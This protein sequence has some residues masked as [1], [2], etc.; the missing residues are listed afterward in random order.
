MKTKKGAL[1]AAA[2]CRTSGEGQRDNTSIPTQREKIQDFAKANGWTVV[3]WYIDECRS[4]AKIEGRDQFKLMMKDAALEK[5]DV[6]VP[7]DTTRFGRDGVDILGS[8]KFLKQ[9]FG[10]CT[11]DTKSQF[12]NRNSRHGLINFLHAGVAEDERLRILERTSNGRIGKAKA[13]KPWSSKLPVGRSYDKD[14]DKWFVNEHGKMIAKLLRRFV[15]G[16]TLNNLCKEYGIPN[17]T[18]ISK[19][20]HHGQLSGTYEVHFRS[21]DI[22]V[23]EVVS[24]PA[25]PE[26][27]PAK[28]LEKV[29]ARLDHN[30]TFNR[31]DAA[32]SYLLSGFIRCGHCGR[33]LTGQKQL[34]Y[35]HFKGKCPVVSIRRDV[36][37][38][39]VLDHL[40]GSFLD[41]PAFQ[42]AIEAAMPSDDSRQALEQERERIERQLNKERVKLDRLVDL[43]L[44]GGDKSLLLDKQVSL[45][46]Q[47]ALLAN[48]LDEITGKLGEMPEREATARAAA[49]IRLRLKQRQRRKDWRKLPLGE[50]QEF[51]RFLF[52]DKKEHGIFIERIKNVRWVITFKGVVALEQDVLTAEI[53]GNSMVKPCSDYRS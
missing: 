32:S 20:V 18:R 11:V 3:K 52:G 22:D 24:V 53:Q 30:R 43:I 4:G 28:L 13:G 46:S 26:V 1:R 25:V 23:D 35:R 39:A 14:K 19:I 17:Q 10:I 37:E 31:T 40:F 16:E 51:L 48:R 38:T 42:K 45:K 27:V 33:A 49:K 9:T 29:L 47:L 6:V 21:A 34:R 50:I 15:A 7:F 12:D 5:F 8:A 41:E 2:Y 36:I 44:D